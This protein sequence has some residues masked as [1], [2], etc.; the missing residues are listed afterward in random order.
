LTRSAKA[1]FNLGSTIVVRTSVNEATRNALSCVARGF[2]G[3]TNNLVLESPCTASGGTSPSIVFK[4]SFLGPLAA[5]A[6]FVDVYSGHD[7]QHFAYL[8]KNVNG[9]SGEIWDLFYCQSCSGNKW[10]LQ[11]LAGG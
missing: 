11:Q 4:E 9:R 10:R 2:T 5:S 3:E 1:N 6:P 8:A 7:Q